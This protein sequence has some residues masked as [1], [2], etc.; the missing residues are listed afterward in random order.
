[1]MVKNYDESVEINDNPNWS[2]IPDHPYRVLIVG[3]SGS[4]KINALLNLMKHQ[5]PDL[6]VRQRSI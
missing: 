2:Y 4:G 6:F 5:R 3:G 1:M